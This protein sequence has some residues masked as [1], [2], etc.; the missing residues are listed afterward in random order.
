MK[1]PNKVTTYQE[2]TLSKF[3]I[4]LDKLKLH[5]YLIPSLYK[6]VK[7]K[8]SIRDFHDA[9]VCLYALGEITIQKEY[10]HYVK[11]IIL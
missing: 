6:E 8:M 10:L 9:L 2:S 7:N 11:G 4:I 3:P 1:L 5:D